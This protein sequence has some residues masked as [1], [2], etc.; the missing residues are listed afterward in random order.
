MDELKWNKH[1][2]Q[3]LYTPPFVQLGMERA[4]VDQLHLVFLNVFKLLFNY[5]IHQALPGKYLALDTHV[6]ACSPAPPLPT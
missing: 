5:T 4:G 3:L 2:Y 1:R 6:L